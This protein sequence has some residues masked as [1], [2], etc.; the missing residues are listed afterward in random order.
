MKFETRIYDI[1]RKRRRQKEIGNHLPGTLSW[2]RDEL[3]TGL[4][5]KITKTSKSISK[6]LTHIYKI[7]I[8]IIIKKIA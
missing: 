5:A 7:I 1:S 8:I 3:V 4:A 2:G 6:C